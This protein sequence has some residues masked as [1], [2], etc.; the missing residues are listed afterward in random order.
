MD[1]RSLSAQERI[2]LAEE[3]WESVRNN[4]D[5]VSVTNDQKQILDARLDALET[6]RELGDPW[7]DIKARFIG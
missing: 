6:D 7:T 5:E 1:I 3:L 4:S 2:S